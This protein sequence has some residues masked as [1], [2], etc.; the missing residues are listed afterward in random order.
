MVYK[1]L[2]AD[3]ETWI[4]KGIIKAIQWESLKLQL[5]GE[6]GDG[7]EAL[8]MSVA[9]QPHII[10]S[11]VRMPSMDGLTLSEEVTKI[12][13]NTK[14]IIIS[15]Y[16]E[17]QYVKRAINA[18]AVNYILKPINREEINGA[19]KKAIDRIEA[20]GQL[21]ELKN[22]IPV[23]MEKLICDA[24]TYNDS[25]Q[26]VAVKEWLKKLSLEGDEYCIAAVQTNRKL[27]DFK[28]FRKVLYNIVRNIAEADFYV[29][30]FDLNSGNI[31]ILVIRR[32][33]ERKIETFLKRAVLAL[34]KESEVGF[35]IGVGNTYEHIEDIYLS[36]VDAIKALDG[37]AAA[38]KDDVLLYSNDVLF[39]E[40]KYPLDLHKSYV[41]CIVLNER[42]K[43][44]V[45]LS[46]IEEYF[47]NTAGK[48]VL[49]LCCFGYCK[50]IASP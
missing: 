10:I 20:Q 17:F 40:N 44:A 49:F 7:E 47:E 45:V 9:L 46:G 24:L 23:F 48:K 32:K 6:T 36:Y 4:R 30:V 19:I 41:S 29:S 39:I 1:V 31:G 42:C 18:D 34:K 50:N 3:D 12:L 21:E 33:N 22:N 11:D 43:I 26:L 14:I 25:E 28:A 27:Q 38:G 15:G 13:P 5:V 37:R 2:I 16:D 8:S 35:S